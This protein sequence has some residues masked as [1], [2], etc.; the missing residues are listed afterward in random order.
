[1][2][3]IPLGIIPMSIIPNSPFQFGKTVSSKLFVNREKEKNRIG[4]NFK[5]G[6]NTILISPRRWGKT[7]LVRETARLVSLQEKN[8]LFC[9]IDVFSVLN[10]EEFYETLAR[11]LIKCSSS[12]IEDWLSAGKDFFKAIVPRFSYG[13]RKS[14]V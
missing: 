13:D 6:I 2:G 10:E 3:I 9:F 11:E 1:M 12:K 4:E 14:V 5:S 7:S 8:L